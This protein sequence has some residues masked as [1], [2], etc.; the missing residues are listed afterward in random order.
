MAPVRVRAR[1][2]SQAHGREREG[3]AIREERGNREGQSAAYL[4]SERMVR[5]FDENTLDSPR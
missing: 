2:K 3:V 4:D 5:I 1:D